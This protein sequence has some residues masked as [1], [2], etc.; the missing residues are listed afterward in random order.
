L[1]ILDL[2]AFNG[3]NIYIQGPAVLLEVKVYKWEY[4]Q[5]GYLEKSI[6]K[7]F[8]NYNRLN[9]LPI[10]TGVIIEDVN[11]FI[12]RV[13]SLCLYIKTLVGDELGCGKC[14]HIGEN[15]FYMVFTCS[16]TAIGNAC[17]LLAIRIIN[18][19][20]KG[21]EIDLDCELRGIECLK[22]R[23]SYGPGMKAIIKEALDREIPVTEVP[24]EDVIRLGYGKHQRFI[25]S[26]AL[27]GNGIPKEIIRNEWLLR[28]IL[29]EAGLPVVEW[30]SCLSLEEILIHAKEMGY[31]IFLRSKS[32]KNLCS[33][34][35]NSM[36]DIKVEY[37][38]LRAYGD[39]TIIEKPLYARSYQI[40]LIDKKVITVAENTSC[41]IDCAKT[42]YTDAKCGQGFYS[43]IYTVYIDPQN[44][45]LAINASQ[46]VKAH[47][48]LINLLLPDISRPL[49]KGSGAVS[50][51]SVSPEE[52]INVVDDVKSRE[53]IASTI[54]NLMFSSEGRPSMPIISVTGTNGK[55]TTVRMLGKILGLEGYRVGMTTTHGI[56]I[57]DI[58]IEAGDA[59]G[60]KSANRL[61]NNGEIDIAVLETARGGIIREGLAYDKADVAIFTNMT[62]DHVGQ[63]GISTIEELLDA[64]ALVIQ[65]V[66]KDGTCILNA[67]DGLLM[68][69]KG[70]AGGKLILFGAD[71]QNHY[72]KEHLCSGGCGVFR[73]GDN[74][75]IQEGEL[76]ELII[77]VADIPATID[78]GLIHNIYNSM[79]AIGAA[80]TLKIPYR[81]IVRALNAFSCDPRVNPGR[82]N[83]YELGGIKVILDFGHNIDGYR[84][85]IEGLKSLKPGRLVGII[86]IPGNRNNEEI[87]KVGKLCGKNFDRILIREDLDLR[88]RQPE[89]VADIILLGAIDA[90]MDR[91][92]VEIVPDEQKALKKLLSEAQ[93]GDVIAVFYDKIDP[94]EEIIKKYLKSEAFKKK[95]A[96]LSPH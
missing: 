28:S 44:V 57:N 88:G 68:K 24:C 39:E 69:I 87:R 54:L 59:A 12:E 84:V 65:E 60:P 51:I 77:N 10:K 90:G 20:L 92:S 22:S 27:E 17:G 93:N 11:S 48:A 47:I 38:K 49:K 91:N 31:P 42:S 96:I 52:I 25:T 30:E 78:G 80:Y 18:S 23:Y 73:Q 58:C 46:A 86:G 19:I 7:K 13:L 36:Q 16:S 89:E 14:K 56:H 26:S 9:L 83:I 85:T 33:L 62:E 72:L 66:K 3:P 6:I 94:L 1:E 43:K 41:D 70:K 45:R 64:K 61:L 8:E 76:K 29:K 35:I 74:I 71:P 55:T 34:Q 40:V 63:N 81:T 4:E 32:K 21:T 37:L 79:A 53:K 15:E 82:F 50:S 5:V 67:D 2:R 75:F 95:R